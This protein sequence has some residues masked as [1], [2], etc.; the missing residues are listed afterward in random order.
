MKI[1]GRRRP[2]VD[3]G[4]GVRKGDGAEEDVVAEDGQVDSDGNVSGVNSRVGD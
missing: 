1:A 3:E 4:S 2:C